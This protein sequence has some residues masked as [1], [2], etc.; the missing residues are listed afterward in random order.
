MLS[1]QSF[2]SVHLLWCD[3][4]DLMTGLPESPF[5]ACK[6]TGVA[7]H[8]IQYP[9]MFRCLQ[10]Q[11]AYSSSTVLKTQVHVSFGSLCDLKKQKQAS[12]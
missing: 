10:Q 5:S 9:R 11:A 3:L 1:D 4:S 12:W 8:D 2:L 7:A 6:C